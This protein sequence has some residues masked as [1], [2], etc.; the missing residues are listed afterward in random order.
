MTDISILRDLRTTLDQFGTFLLTDICPS[1]NDIIFIKNYFDKMEM[2]SLMENFVEY[3]LPYQ[4]QIHRRN[5]KLFLHN[6]KI[7]GNL[8]HDKITKFSQLMNG[9]QISQENEITIWEYFRTI[10]GL[11]NEYKKFLKR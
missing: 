6:K 10:V 8:P 9:E 4:D 2:K 1:D 5:K 11:C 7:F 3:L